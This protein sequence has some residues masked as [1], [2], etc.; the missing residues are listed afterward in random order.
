ML[1]SELVRCGFTI[2]YVSTAAIT[3]V[4]TAAK[5]ISARSTVISF[6][7]HLLGYRSSSRIDMGCAF[8]ATMGP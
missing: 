8:N 7:Y 1:I 3:T 6:V 5:K 4:D 2:Q